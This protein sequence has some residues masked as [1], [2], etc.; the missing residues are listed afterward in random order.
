MKRVT[1]MISEDLDKKLHM[2]QAKRIQN[3]NKSISYSQIL[4]ECIREGLKRQKS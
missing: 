1:V 2:L 3:T 4:N